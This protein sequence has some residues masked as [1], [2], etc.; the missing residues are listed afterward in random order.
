LEERKALAQELSRI[1]SNIHRTK[2]SYFLVYEK[3]REEQKMRELVEQMRVS[4]REYEIIDH[5]DADLHQ[6]LIKSS[7]L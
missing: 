5:R 3:T 7:A 4:G 1:R 2:D 6:H